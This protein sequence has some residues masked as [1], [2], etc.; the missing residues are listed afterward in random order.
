MVEHLWTPWRYLYISGLDKSA[1]GCVFC[2]VL[3]QEDDERV[4][5][6]YRGQTAFVILNLYPYTT[7]HLL[8]VPYR[9]FPLL[10][11][12]S[13]VETREIMV[14]AQHSQRV[15]GEVYNPQGFNM[16][17]NLGRCAGA[18]I[19][20]HL[21]MHVLPRWAGDTNFISVIGETRVIPEDLAITYRKLYP[22]FA[23]FSS[24]AQEP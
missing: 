1:T 15:L 21:H 20:D 16:G 8:V 2:S 24:S 6:V 23:T 11:D 10:S 14:L 22:R 18:G 13:P 12:A 9:H 7:G 3:Q 17:L 4:Y 19:V 5:I